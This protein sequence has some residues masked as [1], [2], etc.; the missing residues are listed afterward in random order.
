MAKKEAFVAKGYHKSETYQKADAA[1]RKE[2]DRY[3]KEQQLTDEQMNWMMYLEDLRATPKEQKQKGNRPAEMLVLGSMV[4]FLIAANMGVRSFMLIASVFFILAAALYLTGALN[5][6]SAAIRKVKKQLKN[7]C[8]KA[9]TYTE[10]A[11][12]NKQED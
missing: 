1:G 11:K 6:Y 3:K 10:W 9:Q 7:L 12:K 8:P 5:P 4:T 2:L